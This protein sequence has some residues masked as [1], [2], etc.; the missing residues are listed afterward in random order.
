MGHCFISKAQYHWAI[1]RF[2][3]AYDDIVNEGF[4]KADDPE[5]R[6]KFEEL[7]TSFLSNTAKCYMNL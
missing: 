3:S 2:E 1:K 6:L 7:G 5:K 4:G